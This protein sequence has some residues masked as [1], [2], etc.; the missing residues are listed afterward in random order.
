MP[1]RSRPALGIAAL[2]A[3]VGVLTAGTPTPA[4]A[5]DLAG[6]KT[7]TLHTRDGRSLPIGQ[8]DFRPDSG[9]IAYA[10]DVDH[11]RFKDFFLSMKEFKCLE[12]ET[13]VFCHVP[14]PY[15]HPRT[16]TATDL[17]WLEHELLFFFK[18]PQDFGAKL[19]NGILVRLEATPKGWVGTPMAVDLNQIGAP[20]DTATVAP[21]GAGERSE[22]DLAKRWFNRITIE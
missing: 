12:S 19:W 6:T 13:E 22:I 10:V 17:S 9:R 3:I 8:V 7:I 20:P 5:G 18:T 21:Y 11:R 15:A 1:N 14:Y 16:V 2:A 4:Q